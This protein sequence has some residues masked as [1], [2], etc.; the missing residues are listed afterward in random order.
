MRR[1]ISR[2]L[3][4]LILPHGSLITRNLRSY[5]KQRQSNRLKWFRSNS[6][7][8]FFDSV[9]KSDWVS[10]YIQ[11]LSL[12]SSPILLLALNDLTVDICVQ[13]R[14]VL[15]SIMTFLQSK[16]KFVDCR[17]PL[18]KIKNR[19]NFTV[20]SLTERVVV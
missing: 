10:S 5:C 18:E 6:C 20:K 12:S 14:G 17:L 3:L 11:F 13:W 4:R 15:K 7:V 19:E 1:I 8:F 2:V 16:V 9:A